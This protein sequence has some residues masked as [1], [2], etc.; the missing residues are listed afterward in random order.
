MTPFYGKKIFKNAAWYQYTWVRVANFEPLY[1]RHIWVKIQSFCAHWTGN[2]L[3]FSKL[4]LMLMSHLVGSS[5]DTRLS[6]CHVGHRHSAL[7][8]CWWPLWP[9]HPPY[10]QLTSHHVSLL[11]PASQMSKPQPSCSQHAKTLQIPKT[12]SISS[13]AEK[14]RGMN[15]SSESLGHEMVLYPSPKLFYQFNYNT[16]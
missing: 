12:E 15:L 16:G 13:L 3:N 7:T 8:P 11:P 5:H 14:E 6:W 10:S 2:F 4:T 9:C 1:L